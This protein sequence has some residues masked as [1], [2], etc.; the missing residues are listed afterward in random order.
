MIGPTR[1]RKGGH[2]WNYYTKTFLPVQLAIGLI[3]C[4]TYR[5]A[6]PDLGPAATVFI[7][8]QVSAV[9]GAMWANRLQRRM[10]SVT[11]RLIN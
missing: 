6:A 5:A 11:S 4:L 2:I 8:M 10:T 1:I 7:V 3:C 9:I